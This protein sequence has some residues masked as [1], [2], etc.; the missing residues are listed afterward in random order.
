MPPWLGGAGGP[1]TLAPGETLTFS[2]VLK[3][4]RYIV[5]CGH[6]SPDGM[7]HVDRGMYRMLTI[8]GRYSDAI[9]PADATLVL[10]EHAITFFGEPRAGD[11]GFLIANEGSRTH[12]ALL[13]RLPPGVA[14]E[15]ELEW[16][17][18]GGRGSRPGHPVGGVIELPAGHSVR[19]R[20]DL[21]PGRYAIFCSVAEGGTRHFDR[22][23]TRTFEVR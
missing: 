16:F 4:G 20:M 17:R 11:Y 5:M 9:R 22:G 2:G 21:R 8:E 3:P 7:P 18:S 10:S 6:P 23:M 14:M 1:G 13:V 19:V 12:Q 15:R